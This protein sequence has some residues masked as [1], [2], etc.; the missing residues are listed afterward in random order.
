[1][2]LD[3]PGKVD[4][5]LSMGAITAPGGHPEALYVDVLRQRV[6]PQL[7]PEDFL[8]DAF[9]Y[10]T[11]P[12]DIDPVLDRLVAQHAQF[13]KLMVIFSEE[14]AKRKDDPAYRGYKGV[15]PALVPAIAR[16]A[17]RRGLRLA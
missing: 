14:Y 17:H 8:G 1:K 13:V 2:A 7:K 5:V 11:K 4:A 3:G 12:G 10:V 9:H 15:D 6:Y 16:A